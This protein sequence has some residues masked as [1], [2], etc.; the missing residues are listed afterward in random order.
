[1]TK[2]DPGKVEGMHPIMCGIL[3]DSEKKKNV[4]DRSKTGMTE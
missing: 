2:I 4:R 1:M 3:K